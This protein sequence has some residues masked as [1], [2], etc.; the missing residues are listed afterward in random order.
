MS[1][2]CIV[3]AQQE[4]IWAVAIT[5]FGLASMMSANIIPL[6]LE[7]YSDFKI[8]SKTDSAKF[9]KTFH[10]FSSLL[11]VI[12]IFYLSRLIVPDFTNYIVIPC[13]IWVFVGREEVVEEYLKGIFGLP[14]KSKIN[15]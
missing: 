13:L 14:N 1:G 12:G 11:V 5:G 3:C 8:I 7:R 15:K 2:E 4:L 6:I 9:T 10:L